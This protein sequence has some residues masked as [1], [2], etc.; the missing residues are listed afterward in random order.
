MSQ[1]PRTRV[2]APVALPPLTP[3]EAEIHPL[4]R[5][6]T[7]PAIHWNILEEP[8]PVST[9]ISSHIGPFGSFGGHWMFEPATNPPLTSVCIRAPIILDRPIVV[10]PSHSHHR[11]RY[12]TVIDVLTAVHQ[13][14]SG[15]RARGNQSSRASEAANLTIDGVTLPSMDSNIVGMSLLLRPDITRS[16]TLITRHESGLRSFTYNGNVRLRDSHAQ[17]LSQI[18]PEVWLWSGLTPSTEERDVWL[19]HFAR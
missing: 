1:H 4:L 7:S 3:S 6:H 18:D 17:R 11:R 16:H 13:A 2:L 10:F 5:L 14:I 9:S 8:S 12:V 15:S 19:L